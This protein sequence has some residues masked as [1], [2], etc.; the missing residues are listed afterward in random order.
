MITVPIKLAGGYGLE[1]HYSN[2]VVVVLQMV[3]G[4]HRSVE[5]VVLCDVVLCDVLY[6]PALF[7][8]VLYCTALY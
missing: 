8:A 2:G 7:G 3:L 4:L 5:D 1:G 6:S